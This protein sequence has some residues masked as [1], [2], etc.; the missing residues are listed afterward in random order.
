[1]HSQTFT[2]RSV[3]QL[4]E[5]LE[6]TVIHRDAD[7]LIQIFAACSAEIAREYSSLIKHSIPNSVIIGASAQFAIANGRTLEGECVVHL[8]QFSTSE[9]FAYHT[10]IESEIK[11]TCS[12][13]A[14][15]LRRHP[16]RKAMIGFA[17]GIDANDYA[18]FS[19]LTRYE[20]ML[21]ISGGVAQDVNDESWVLLNQTTYNRHIVT[22]L[23][24]GEQLN[25]ER[26]CFTEWHP[27][28]REFEV[29]EAEFGR[30]Y[31]LDG[32]PPLQY[33]KKY[34][35]Q[36]HPIAFEVARDFPLLKHTQS[37][38]DT[39]VPTAISADGSMD[40]GSDLQKGDRV[41]FCYNHPSLTINQVNG[42]VKRLK[43]FAPQALFIYNC[44]SRLDF[45]EG[46][47]ELEVF[48]QLPDVAAQ[49]FFCMGE[50]FHTAG[51]HLIKHHSMTILA[52]NEREHSADAPPLISEQPVAVKDNLS[53]LFSLI[54]NSLDDVDNMQQQME[55]RLKAQSNSLLASYRIDPKTELPNRS[56]LKERL[57][58]FTHRDHLISVKV[59]NF[60][61]V[62]EKYGYEIGDLL[63]K[64]LT[65]HIKQT[66]A[67]HVPN[68]L[69]SLYSLGIAEWALVFNSYMTQ[70]EIKEYFI[71]LADYTEKLN[72]EPVGLPEMDYL[73]VSVR[74][75]LVSRDSFPVDSPD[76][77]LLKSI[78]SRRFATKNH[79]FIASASELRSEERQRQE[80]FGWLNSVSRAVQ[81]KNVIAYAQG[82]VSVENNQPSFY[83]CLVRIEEEGKIIMP[84]QFLPVI[85]GT[86]L[87]ARLSHQMI[88]ETFR[89]MRN[90]SESFSINLSPQDMLSDRTMY[91]LEQEVVQLSDPSRFGV[92]VLETEQIKDYNR[93]REICDHFRAMGVRIVVD[94][95]GSGYSNIDEIIKLEPHIIKVDGSLVRNIDR[96]PK[97]R[98]ITQQLVNLCKVFNAKTVAEFVHNKQV[99]DL[100]TDMGFDYLQGFY[101]FEPKPIELI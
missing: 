48:D 6:R 54:K 52:L 33:Y 20:P 95:F 1:M 99:A 79:Q 62:N 56:V 27:I 39:F 28:G 5:Q 94:D 13:I 2:F 66:I 65:T 77:L 22:V 36:D 46:D 4:I 40:F 85:E 90:R 42:A 67:Q 96:D 49:G 72:F 73:S 55:Q 25:V 81:R 61:Q 41:R 8:T 75:G 43:R 80:E 101:F 98:A 50:F 91:L 15:M 82:I 14:P 7:Y 93:M 57:E 97:Q 88:K 76:E 18:L 47:E 19:Q 37:G 3:N 51:K 44:L 64:D 35:N 87:Y 92:E 12:D 30:V 69:V 26:Q 32:Q 10:P 63:L 83:E 38:Q 89:H 86:H 100:A 84:G 68:G 45:M 58:Q 34:L 60:P 31:A 74:G 70:E 24:C 59:T 9:I 21:P 17:D 16:H 23:L 71:G 53:P 29:T 11:E 78:E